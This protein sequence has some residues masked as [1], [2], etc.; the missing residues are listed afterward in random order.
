MHLQACALML[1]N[2]AFR[3]CSNAPMPCIWI[4]DSEKLFVH[5]FPR[6]PPAWRF[7]LGCA[8]QEAAIV[9]G[10]DAGNND[11]G[12]LKATCQYTIHNIHKSSGK[13]GQVGASIVHFNDQL[14]MS[15]G[16]RSPDERIRRG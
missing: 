6:S 5:H 2:P 16:M 11:A 13:H 10:T 15:G 4:D 12:N 9:Q 14:K 3:V 7:C 8:I 1:L